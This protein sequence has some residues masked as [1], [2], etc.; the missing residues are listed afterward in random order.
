MK[1][2]FEERFGAKGGRRTE[3]T[4]RHTCWALTAHSSRDWVGQEVAGVRE[5]FGNGMRSIFMVFFLPLSSMPSSHDRMI[6]SR[7]VS[8]AT[9]KTVGYAGR[10]GV[11]N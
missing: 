1:D 2:F 4:E 8:H 10:T 5:A 7:K 6:R 11:S 9:T 3:R